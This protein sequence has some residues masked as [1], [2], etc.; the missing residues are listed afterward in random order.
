MLPLAALW[1]IHSTHSFNRGIDYTS[2]MQNMA[3]GEQLTP[4]DAPD[5]HNPDE[6]TPEEEDEWGDFDEGTTAPVA[7]P[8]AAP[9]PPEFQ[10]LDAD[11]RPEPAAMQQQAAVPQEPK[12]T[13][14]ACLSEWDAAL[15]PA[16]SPGAACM[17]KISPGHMP[18]R[19]MACSCHL[20]S[21]THCHSVSVLVSFL[22]LPFA[23]C[24]CPA[25]TWN[26]DPSIGEPFFSLVAC[27]I[28]K[29]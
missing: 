28:Y 11:T 7:V 3:E 10:H 29:R 21:S 18:H 23:G 8:V 12:A 1:T 22:C 19:C 27:Y 4:P 14:L 26:G 25:G 6:P 24:L 13:G 9:E 20:V 5:A 2:A 15:G 17:Q 16:V